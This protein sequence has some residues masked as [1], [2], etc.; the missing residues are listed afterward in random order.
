MSELF[1]NFTPAGN[2]LTD[3]DNYYDKTQD[4]IGVLS[5]V[6]E[7]LVYIEGEG[8]LSHSKSWK[9]PDSYQGPRRD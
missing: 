2:S 8:D 9:K 5:W 7:K 4:V 3:Y 6:S 1:W